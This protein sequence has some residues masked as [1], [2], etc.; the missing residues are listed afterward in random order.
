MTDTTH[1]H[2]PVHPTS[3]EHLGAVEGDRPGDSGEGNENAGAL[4][5]NGL[6]KNKVAIS[7]DSIG[8]RSDETQG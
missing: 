7:E 5:E 6:P 1:Q 3:D 4:D 2:P 8:A